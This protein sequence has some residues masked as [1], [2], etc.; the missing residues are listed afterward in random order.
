MLRC[1]MATRQIV[2]IQ[3]GGKKSR[4]F[5]FPPIIDNMFTF[6][7]RRARCNQRQRVGIE[8]VLGGKHAGG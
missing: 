5:R 6:Y 3:A 1:G 2:L 4:G 8:F 7:P